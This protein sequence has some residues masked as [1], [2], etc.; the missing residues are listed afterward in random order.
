MSFASTFGTQGTTTV[1][2]PTASKAV[3]IKYVSYSN[4]TGV[5]GKVSLEFSSGDAILPITLGSIGIFAS[6]IVAGNLQGV[7]D[8]TLSLV[9]DIASQTVDVFIIGEEV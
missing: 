6:N 3:K 4:R 1:W 9:V 8:A 2:D 5:E 7:I